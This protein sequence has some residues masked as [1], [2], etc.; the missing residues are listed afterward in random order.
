LR[1][2]LDRVFVENP[3]ELVVTKGVERSARA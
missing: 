3:N 2:Y 1:M